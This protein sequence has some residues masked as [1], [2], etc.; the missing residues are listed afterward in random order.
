M[1]TTNRPTASIET[2]NHIAAME[3]QVRQLFNCEPHVDE[4][5]RQHLFERL[6]ELDTR[7]ERLSLRSLGQ[8][9][10]TDL[11]D[12]LTS[13]SRDLDRLESSWTRTSDSYLHRPQHY[14]TLEAA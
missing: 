3:S 9:V 8:Y 13:C 10:D 4:S 2:R 14:G 5:E 11:L 6:A 12:D 7:I 1:K